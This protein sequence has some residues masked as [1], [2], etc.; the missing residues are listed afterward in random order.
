MRFKN[1]LEAVKIDHNLATFL[2]TTALISFFQENETLDFPD[3][4]VLTTFILSVNVFNVNEKTQG[5]IS[6]AVVIFR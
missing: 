4:G 5:K 2:R 1:C 6:D 3:L